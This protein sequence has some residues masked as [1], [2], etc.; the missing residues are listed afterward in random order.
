VIVVSNSSPLITLSR[1]QCFGL[2]PRLFSKIYISSEVYNEVVVAGAGLP[3]AAEV[4]RA[5]WRLSR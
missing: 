2:K 5:D 3:G 4:A 1:V